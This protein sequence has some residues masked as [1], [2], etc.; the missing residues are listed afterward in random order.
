MHKHNAP[1]ALAK[2]LLALQVAATKE[3]IAAQVQYEQDF[4]TQQDQEFRAALTKSGED[5]DK[6]MGVVN[7]TA[8]RF[9]MAADSPMMKNAQVRLM[10]QS[11][12]KAIG[13]PAT[14]T[15]GAAA[16]STLSE[17]AQAEAIIH[18]KTNPEY[19]AYWDGQHAKNKEVKAK[20]MALQEAAVMKERAAAQAGGQRR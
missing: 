14:V 17:R 15:G 7:Q 6:V 10:L 13:E 3:N 16:A 11:V 19:A 5:Y 1:P 20:V 9:G 4:Y 12:A 18:D 8:Q 2:E